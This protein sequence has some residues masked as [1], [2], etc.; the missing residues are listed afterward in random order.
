MS[1]ATNAQ[2]T[3]DAMKEERKQIVDYLRKRGRELVGVA[4]TNQDFFR[5]VA[6]RLAD[7]I[8]AGHHIE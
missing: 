2:N 7:E 5:A 8:E 4:P 6:M 1:I 3:L